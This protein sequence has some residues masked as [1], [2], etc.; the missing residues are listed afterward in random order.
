MGWR[1]VRPE[2]GCGG[3]LV[4][5]HFVRVPK[6]RA[7]LR[8]NGRAATMQG[9][10]VTLRVKRCRLDWMASDPRCSRSRSTPTLNRAAVAVPGLSGRRRRPVGSPRWRPART[11]P[12]RQD[13]GQHR[14]PSLR[15]PEVDALVAVALPAL[16]FDR[17]GPVPGGDCR[18]PDQWG[19]FRHGVRSHARRDVRR[20]PDARV[21]GVV[22]G[23]GPGDGRRR[24]LARLRVGVAAI[25]GVYSVALLGYVIVDA[26]DGQVTATRIAS[27][28]PLLL[29]LAFALLVA[30]ERVGSHRRHGSDGAVDADYPTSA[31]D[32]SSG[33]RRGHLRPI[34]HA[35]PDHAAPSTTT[36]RR[37]G[38]PAQLRWLSMIAPS[39]DEAVT[40]LALSAARGT[41]E[42]LRRSSKPPSKTCGGSSPTSPMP[43]MPTI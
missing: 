28:M 7:S 22:V 20:A 13:H 3:R 9:C 37:I 17:G 11:R 26:F 5:R 29:G 8:A 40:E 39:D 42:R 12:G 32:L 38:K 1:C 43:A 15:T 41:R 18:G 4:P 30:R 35:A 25:T 21:H 36:R 2:V 23:V 31:A 6:S 27:H 24:R 33:R 14:R 19:R 10:G 34:N 16:G